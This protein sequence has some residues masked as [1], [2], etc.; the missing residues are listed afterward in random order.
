M[1]LTSDDVEKGIDEARAGVKAAQASLTLA[2]LEYTR[3]TRLEQQGASP[4]RQ[5]QQVT[6]S[7]DSASAAG[8]SRRSPAGES[9]GR[10]NP[11]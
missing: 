2:E 4:Q 6:Q 10:P 11:D 7:R 9:S 5:Q 1:T 8:G 3:F